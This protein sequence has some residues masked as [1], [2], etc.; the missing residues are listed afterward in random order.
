MSDGLTGNSGGYSEHFRGPGSKDYFRRASLS[1][2]RAAVDEACQSTGWPDEQ[3]SQTNI[4]DPQ[5]GGVKV[6]PFI[7]PEKLSTI[8]QPGEIE[9]CDV[10]GVPLPP[11]I[12]GLGFRKIEDPPFYELGVFEDYG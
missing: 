7:D 2:A 8:G 11:I 1:A 3:K 9:G 6:P 5:P 4:A 10:N 12:T